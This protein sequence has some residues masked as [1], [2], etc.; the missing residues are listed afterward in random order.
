MEAT[1]EHQTTGLLDKIIPPRLEDAG[2]EDCALPA[3]SIKEAFLKAA[4][5][6]KSRATSIFDQEPDCVQDPWPEAKD[7]SDHV[8]PGP[9]G[10]AHDIL[11]GVDVE[12]SPGPCVIEKG[13][14]VVEG[15]GDKVVVGG[16]DVEEKDKEKEKC[17]EDALKGLNIG[18]KE[19]GNSGEDDRDEEDGETPILTEGVV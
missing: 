7:F 3:D 10:G 16:G 9:P 14:D 5:S 11:E 13:R 17:V 1:K 15:M 8:V 6:V 4:A 19:G 12:G 18:D 2:L